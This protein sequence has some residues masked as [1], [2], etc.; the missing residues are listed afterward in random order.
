MIDDGPRDREIMIDILTVR[1][2]EHPN[3]DPDR[4]ALREEV[5]IPGEV[6]QTEAGRGRVRDDAV[7]EGHRNST[8]D[9]DGYVQS[10]VLPDAGQR[11]AWIP[12]IVRQDQQRGQNRGVFLRKA[13]RT[14]QD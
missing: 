11:K 10:P 6:L 8:A 12:E 2:E 1:Q 14:E 5:L 4:A 13:C 3:V 7:D 9:R